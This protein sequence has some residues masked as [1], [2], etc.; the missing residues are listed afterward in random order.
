M[1]SRLFFVKK[2]LN[3]S[4]SKN[5]YLNKGVIYLKKIFP[6]FVVLFSMIFVI[7]VN[8]VS[9]DECFQY[10]GMN[11]Q[12]SACEAASC[13][14]QTNA[15]DPWC[16]FGA[17]GGCCLD[18]GCWQY[19]GNQTG[20]ESA[21]GLNC[22][23]DQYAS[24]TD[25]E[26]NEI[27][28]LCFDDFDGGDWGGMDD[29]CWQFD[30]NQ[31][32]CASSENAQSC[33]WSANDQNQNPW[34]GV[35]TLTDAQNKNINATQDDIGCCEM[36]GCWSYDGNETA[37]D[38]NIAFAGLCE[39]KS[40]VEDPYCPDDV[41]C[42]LTKW[43]DQITDETNCIK[44]KTDL[45]M[46]CEWSNP[47]GEGVCQDQAGG[48]FSFF[49]DTDS[50]M[51]QGGWY[52]STGDCVMPSGEFGGDGS[53]GFMF[54][55][56][57]HCWFADNQPNVCTNITGCAY[58]VEGNGPFG[59]DN[60]SNDNICKD[61]EVGWCEGHDANGPT[62]LNADNTVNLNCSHIELKAACNYGP[63]PNCI[64]SN[65]SAIIGG[66]C[67]AGTSTVQQAT[68]P[69]EYCDAPDAKN[70]YTICM[71]L[72]ENFMM[73]CTWQNTT[74]PIQNCTFNS[75]AVF[76]SS[77]EAEFEIINSEFSCTSAGGTWQTEY[78]LENEILKQDSWCEMTGF[79]DIDSGQGQN[80]KGNCDTSCWACEFQNDGTA[81]VDVSA[82]QNA[83]EY[84]SLGY[85]EWT[86]DSS[87]FNGLGFCDYPYEMES[88]GS[89]DCNVECEGCNF[90]NNPLTA[91]EASVANDGE[92][93]KWVSE[94][95]DNYC[96]DKSKKTCGSD[97]FSC[98]D[99]SACQA[100]SLSC[101][102]DLVNN[103]C[104]P[105]G[106]T[107]EICF[108]GIDDDSDNM[109][110]CN[111]PDCGFDN[112]CGGG[113]I[114]GDCFAQIDE[115]NCEQTPAFEDLNC[116]WMNDTWNPNGWCDMP[117]ANCWNYDDDMIT[118]GATPGCTNESTFSGSVCDMNKTAMDTANCFGYDNESSCG[119]APGN[120][121]WVNNSWGDG[122][123]DYAPFASCMSLNATACDAADDCLWKSDEWSE[124]G[125]GWCD[126]ACFNPDINQTTCENIGS[127]LC[128]WRDMSNTCQPEMFMMMGGS[129][130]GCWQFDGNQTACNEN[131]VTCSYELD[132]Y[133]QNNVSGELSGWCMGKSE[134]NMMAGSNEFI[135]IALD[136]SQESGVSPEI[137]MDDLIM[138]ANDETY[139]FA[140][141]VYQIE[142]SII[143]NGVMVGGEEGQQPVLGT[144][145]GTSKFYY[146]LDTD[147]IEN[148]GCDAQLEDSTNL[149]GFDFLI[150][151][152]AMNTSSGL[153]ETKQLMTCSSGTWNPTNAL[154]TTSKMQSCGF[155]EAGVSISKQ[156]LESFSAFN[157]QE[158]MRIVVT[159]ANGIDNR[160]SPSD[161]VGPGYHTPGTNNFDF[162]DCSNPLNAKDPKCKNFQ[163]FGFNVFEEC[164][165]GIDDDE[166]G[167]IDCFD[168]F[169]ALFQIVLLALHLILLQMQLIKLLLL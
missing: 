149:T 160:L 74:Y 162:V 39:W 155:T 21:S 129:D 120:C 75:N 132:E 117:G 101:S 58:C 81:W 85:C 114:G 92:G 82:A 87:A 146:Y 135:A 147:G 83:C 18:V 145:N 42:C 41:G 104:A 12:Q 67:E 3:N 59:V 68:P 30:G 56:E 28:G 118:C 84:S 106:F 10:G 5:Y 125:D 165:N 142:D 37:C 98:Y 110:D 133:A 66:Y 159:S 139:G 29:A 153:V 158:D 35:K 111:D 94:G 19:D 23:W 27:I 78:Y 22:T 134:F 4:I 49:N 52:N 33:S 99:T 57:A 154:I 112:F 71:E 51:N 126:V 164:K 80:N 148:G 25:P 89:Q 156:D 43:C 161:S 136:E 141:G 95:S 44:L 150:S 97:C 166:N 169:C 90:M 73:P 108:N 130:G 36:K 34:C 124:F 151:Y 50:C 26:G 109:I 115:A 96:V 127:G 17:P 69:A 137:D 168:P 167:L 1:Q 119:D 93:C 103:L 116:T 32:N 157:K 113:D 72:I 2:V 63:L 138:F 38:G 100:S 45:Y 31:N 65:S 40:S 48:G 105:D 122:F 62:Y 7:N 15:T 152:T 163:K 121:Q 131:N 70:N 8:D 14:W 55:G 9:A 144:G 91:C 88:S 128:E 54:G 123:C 11:D 53:G 77:G 60:S 6:V 76:G 20:C 16:P 64:W 102:W 13:M 140:V 79:F 143:C 46:P 24:F 61:V 47:G 86:E 107:G